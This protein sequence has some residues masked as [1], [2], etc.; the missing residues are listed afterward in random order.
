MG[1]LTATASAIM[2][3]WGSTLDSERVQTVIAR[4]R[5]IGEQEDA[6][7]KLRVRA[8]EDELGAKFYGP[9]LCLA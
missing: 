9:E 5:G 1:T 8:R 3:L 7:A 4:L 2:R 6:A